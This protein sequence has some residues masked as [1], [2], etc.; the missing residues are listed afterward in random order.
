MGNKI[1]IEENEHGYFNANGHGLCVLLSTLAV[2]KHMG[3]ANDG[4]D[5]VVGR[6]ANLV[7]SD[8]SLSFLVPI[9]IP[10]TIEEITG[11]E[12]HG[13]VVH[14]RARWY[15]REAG[16]QN[17]DKYGVDREGIDPTMPPLLYNYDERNGCSWHVIAIV[18]YDREKYDVVD[19]GRPISMEAL[20]GPGV[21]Y[22]VRRN[23]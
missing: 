18:G 6:F 20:P 22:I 16:I 23:K 2:L 13:Q 3:V 15:L 17:P 12:F 10:T 5:R 9:Q 7:K 1:T 4:L 19:N 14:P 11:G 8:G 21:F